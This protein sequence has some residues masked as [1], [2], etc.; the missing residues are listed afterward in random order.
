M[1]AQIAVHLH[2][3]NLY[4]YMHAVTFYDYHFLTDTLIGKKKSFMPQQLVGQT[5]LNP[6]YSVV[7]CQLSSKNNGVISILLLGLQVNMR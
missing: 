1:A 2:N 6:A 4:T 7:L 3:N 5:S